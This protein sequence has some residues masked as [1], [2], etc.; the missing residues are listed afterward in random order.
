MVTFEILKHIGI[1]SN[2]GW[3]REVNIVSWNGGAPKVDIREWSDDHTKMSKGIT[4]TENEAEQLCMI[5][6]NY[7]AERS[8]K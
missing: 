2:N 4:M 7:I 5:L 8:V 3:N 6:H 1:I